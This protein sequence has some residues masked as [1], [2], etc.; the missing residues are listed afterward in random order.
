MMPYIQKRYSRI[1]Q[2]GVELLGKETGQ[3]YLLHQDR[4]MCKG[5][6]KVRQRLGLGNGQHTGE[7]VQEAKP[8]TSGETRRETGSCSRT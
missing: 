3:E 7:K 1:N 4:G 6:R 8:S 5:V 2:A